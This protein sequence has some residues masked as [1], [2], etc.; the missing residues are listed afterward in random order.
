MTATSPGSGASTGR[1]R[2][3]ARGTEERS[4]HL[5]AGTDV[6]LLYL[7]LSIYNEKETVEGEHA[8][9]SAEQPFALPARHGAGCRLTA[10]RHRMA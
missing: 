2:C 4:G 7:R 5:A 1:I 3:G 6:V 9:R 8:R 10:A